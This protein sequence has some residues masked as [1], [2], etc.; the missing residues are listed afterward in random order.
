MKGHSNKYIIHA[1]ELLFQ[2]PRPNSSAK[3][4]AVTAQ[5]IRVINQCQV[6]IK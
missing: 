1:A 5:Q 4:V 2:L 3:A 6:V